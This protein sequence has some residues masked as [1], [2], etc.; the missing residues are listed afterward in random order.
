MFMDKY[1]VLQGA[2]LALNR[3]NQTWMVR[4]V[5]DSLVARVLLPDDP[6][7]PPN[8]F[9]ISDE[10][11]QFTFTV[12]LSDK[13]TWKEHDT[14]EEKSSS[15]NFSG[16]NLSFGTSS[17][18]QFGKTSQKSFQFGIGQNGSGSVVFDT[19]TIK[20]PIREYLKNCGWKKAGLFG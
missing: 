18:K 7:A 15:V 13:G 11:R 17:N 9:E 3:P 2:P 8:P 4:I 1:Q 16:G 19:S 12:T 20:E 6:Y 14:L 5:G 10:M